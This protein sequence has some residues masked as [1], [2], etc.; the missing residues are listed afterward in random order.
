[1]PINNKL[2]STTF[3]FLT[4]SKI[5][6]RRLIVG[7]VLSHYL[8]LGTVVVLTSVYIVVY[9]QLERIFHCNWGK[10]CFDKK[11]ADS[12]TI[13]KCWVNTPLK[14]EIQPFF[15]RN[16]LDILFF[17]ILVAEKLLCVGG[18]ITPLRGQFLPPPALPFFPQQAQTTS[19]CSTPMILHPHTLTHTYTDTHTH[20]HT[21]TYTHIHTHL[22][23]RTIWDVHID[24]WKS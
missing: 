15:E 9:M 1:M 14:G 2:P 23:L 17:P 4:P 12:T 13:T 5:S 21:H 24:A 11:N 20:T 18:N 7:Y 22:F 6:I 3:P 10:I 16:A 19:L 8:R